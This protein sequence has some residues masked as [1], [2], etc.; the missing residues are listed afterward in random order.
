QFV[1]GDVQHWWLPPSGQ[2][3][4][5]RISDDR[6]W[7]AYVVAHYVDTTLDVAV[8]DQ[9]L[10]FLE[11]AQI[12]AGDADAFY[13]PGT[14]SGRASLYEHG[15]RAIDSSLAL[16]PHGLPLMGTGD[17]NDGMN[18]V[19]AQGRGESV[20]MAWFLLATIGAFAPFAD[21]RGD[22]A[23]AAFWRDHA[24]A[25]KKVLEGPLGWD[26]EWYR[27]GYYDDGTV[28]G[29]HES[30]ECRIDT[31]AQSWSLMSGVADP[32]HAAQ[33]MAS[34]DKYLV[35]HDDKIALL[36]TPPFEHT[37]LNPG[38]I[39]G[40]PPGIRE[41]GGQYT[42]GAT[43]S[44]FACAL[45]GQG[46]RAGELFDILNPIRH[47]ASAEALARYRVEPYV[48]CADVY[49]VDP[50]VGRG[51]WTWYTGTAGWLYRGAL[52]AILGFRLNGDQLLLRPCIPKSWPGYRIVYRRRDAHGTVTPYEITVENPA[53]VSCGVAFL[54]VDGADQSL[55][56]GDTARL[57]LLGD[58]QVHLV[59]L[60]LG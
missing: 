10:P 43:W 8:L 18:N 59:R 1:Q 31:I 50:Y 55:Q 5:T 42:H 38:Y 35:R 6:V 21:E 48:A 58:G 4:R 57:H 13:Q 23:R 17:W 22:G 15:A 49:S 26:G 34:V 30:E 51:G 41:N 53:G 32:A 46:D 33:A 7:L 25:L 16:G 9:S 11:G 52:E 28:L 24:T 47:S 36:F 29:S 56:G 39:K 45:L 2:G 12:K 40:Y 19:G 20:W 37:P 44:I 60:V 54:A 3:I 27:R 14:S